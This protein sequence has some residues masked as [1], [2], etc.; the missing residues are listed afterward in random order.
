VGDVCSIARRLWPRV[1]AGDRIA[2][3]AVSAIGPTVLPLDEAGRPLRTG[4]PVRR[5]HAG[6]AQ[7]AALEAGMARRLAAWSGM[8]LSSQASGPKIAW[9]AE[10]EP[11][12][13]AARAGS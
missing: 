3:V 4:D 1:P 8:D 6:A 7:I 2:A 9:L 11:E 10:H 12:V 13:H 5:R